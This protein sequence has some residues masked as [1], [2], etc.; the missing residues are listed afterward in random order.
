MVVRRRLRAVLLPLGLYA[1]SALVV[2]FFV[3]QAHNGSRGLEAKRELKRQ[4]YVLQAER[5][6]VRAER[7]EWE[8]RVVLLRSDGIDRDLLEERAR[9]LLGRVHRNDVVVITP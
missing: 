1:V 7:V 9:T 3:N 8:R 4:A 6:G 5:D 2:G